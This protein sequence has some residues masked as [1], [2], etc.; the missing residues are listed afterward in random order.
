[1]D[2]TITYLFNPKR[3]TT[4]SSLKEYDVDYKE[5]ILELT[6]SMFDNTHPGLQNSFRNYVHDCIQYLKQQDLEKI[7]EKEQKTDKEILPINGDQ[8]IFA[9]KKIDI[10]INKKN[11]IKKMYGLSKSTTKPDHLSLP[12]TN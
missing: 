10:L 11:N 2:P 5:T 9:P 6:S 7:K 3:K 4:V 1:M 12:N 8:F